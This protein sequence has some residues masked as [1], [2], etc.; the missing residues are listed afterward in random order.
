[1]FKFKNVFLSVLFFSFIASINSFSE[2]IDVKDIHEQ[3]VKNVDRHFYQGQVLNGT[4]DVIIK[5]PTKLTFNSNICD[6]PMSTVKTVHVEFVNGIINY[7]TIQCY[8]YSNSLLFETINNLDSTFTAKS[9][10]TSSRLRRVF[11]YDSSFSLTNISTFYLSGELFE[12]TSYDNKNK[13]I[14]TTEYNKDKSIKKIKT[15]KNGKL[16]NVEIK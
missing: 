1:M 8:S 14:V 16:K 6:N 9:Y 10:D 7:R 15:F 4:Y 11:N 13:L 3:T 12:F 5:D 2:T